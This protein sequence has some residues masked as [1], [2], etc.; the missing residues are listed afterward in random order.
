M[1][2]RQWIGVAMGSVALAMF[3]YMAMQ[4]IDAQNLL[5]DILG[6]L[7][8]ASPA[9]VGAYLVW[10][11]PDN[12]VGLILA[13][14]GL[15]FT[16]GVIGESLAAID[17]PLT[18]WGVWFGTWQWALS[19]G[20]ILVLLPLRFPDGRLPSSRYRW[21]TPV[22]LVGLTMLVFGNAFKESALVT[23][24]DRQI[25]IAL[26]MG[27]PLSADVF[28]TVS[29]F[30]LALMLV[31]IGGAVVGAVMRFRRSTDIEHQQ[32]KVFAGALCVSIVGMALNLILYEMGNEP[33][34]NA[35][36]AIWVLILVAS[37]ALAVL[38]YRLYDFDR[39]VSRTASYALLV[40]ILGAVYVV[41]AVWLPT[42]IVGE[43]SP[44]FVAGTT[45]AVAAL[46]TPI[47]RRVMNWVDRRFYRS[48]YQMEL[49]IHEFSSHLQ[50]Q[51]DP[52]QMASACV[53][54]ITDT[55]RPTTAGVWVRG[56]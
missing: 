21:V 37:I 32:M 45:L 38:R 46:F 8:F 9:V 10:R 54:L 5:V 43:E 12:P 48:R 28:D 7:A 49:V 4:D 19:M 2:W 55:L 53:G 25:E 39:V 23:V 41:G 29:L 42:R 47:R 22:M 34:A 30:G 51:V 20:L 26:P 35:L 14:F 6:L 17:S 24:G 27:L 15:T 1:R 3:I 40:L 52:D 11:L 33:A 50:D 36:F 56:E 13:G 44:L 31:A 16:L 18:S